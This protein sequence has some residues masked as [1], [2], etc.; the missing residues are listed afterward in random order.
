MPGF[1][2]LHSSSLITR[3]IWML[4]KFYTFTLCCIDFSPKFQNLG[5]GKVEGED[6]GMNLYIP[7]IDINGWRF[8]IKDTSPSK[9]WSLWELKN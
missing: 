2:A 8:Y 7:P 9:L 1:E 5:V 6:G 3:K 4:E